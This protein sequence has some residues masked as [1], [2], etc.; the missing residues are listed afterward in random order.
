MQR[1]L[2]LARTARGGVLAGPADLG[3]ERA[4]TKGRRAS[5]FPTSSRRAS[6]PSQCRVPAHPI[7][8]RLL[9]VTGLP[10][11]APSA[12]RSGRVSPTLATHVEADFGLSLPIILDGGATRHG[13]RKH[14]AGRERQRAAPAQAGCTAARGHR[15]GDRSCAGR[16]C[17]RCRESR[18]RPDSCGPLRAARG[19]EAQRGRCAAGRGAARLRTR[20]LATIG[21]AINLSSTGDLVE[22]A[23]R[24]V[25]GAARTGPARRPRAIA[26]MSIPDTGLGE[27]INDRLIRPRRRAPALTCPARGEAI[28]PRGFATT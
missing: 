17:H 8:R 26:V 12:N 18:H 1:F 3:H 15:E 16:G 24:P 22:A 9:E 6:R 7:A 11:A 23:T 10:L 25:R 27:A 5:G 20:P 28:H 4:R 2:D 19:A 13:P 14:S 21:P